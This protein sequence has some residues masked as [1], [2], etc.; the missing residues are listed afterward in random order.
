MSASSSD[1][2]MACPAN[3]GAHC[4]HYQEGDGDCCECQKGLA[5]CDECGWAGEQAAG[6]E[7]SA[8]GTIDPNLCPGCGDFICHSM[9]DCKLGEPL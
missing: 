8:E 3:G 5:H 2:Q 6:A 4:L 7:V 1:V 9:E